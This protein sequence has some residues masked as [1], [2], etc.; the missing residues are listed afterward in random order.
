MVRGTVAPRYIV[1]RIAAGFLT[2][3]RAFG[4]AKENGKD[5]NK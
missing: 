2:D 5:D 3:A 4:K 1:G